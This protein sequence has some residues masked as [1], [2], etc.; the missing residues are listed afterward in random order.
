MHLFYN[1][2]KKAMLLD[3]DR[4]VGVIDGK[5]IYYSQVLFENLFYLF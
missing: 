1:L 5:S 3:Q 4:A 2:E